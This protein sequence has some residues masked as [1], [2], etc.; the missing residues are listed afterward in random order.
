MKKGDGREVTFWK[1]IPLQL[2]Q[3]L[4]K[5]YKGDL[6]MFDYSMSKYF[7][8][9][10]VEFRWQLPSWS[11]KTIKWRVDHNQLMYRGLST[12]VYIII[13]MVRWQLTYIDHN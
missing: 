7:E 6:E 3:N 9:L 2:V 1:D 12:E 11:W 13:N 4:Y 5:F 10:G 8:G